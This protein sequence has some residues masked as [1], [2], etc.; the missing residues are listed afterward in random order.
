MQVIQDSTGSVVSINISTTSVIYVKKDIEPVKF[1]VI[2]K[3][4][5][6]IPSEFPPLMIS[7]KRKGI[8]HDQ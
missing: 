6:D 7:N 2:D 3:P 1:L 8:R 5:N 4:V